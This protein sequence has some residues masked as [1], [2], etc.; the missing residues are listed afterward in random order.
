MDKIVKT[1]EE[2]QKEYSAEVLDP[3]GWNR[4]DFDFSFNV[5]LIS[6][7]EFERRMARSTTEGF[8]I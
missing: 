2:W 5:E 1:S 7:E 6:R 4:R 3:D 8:K